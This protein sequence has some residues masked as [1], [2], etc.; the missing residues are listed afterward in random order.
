MPP[1]ADIAVTLSGCNKRGFR[2]IADDLLT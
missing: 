1:K 2:E